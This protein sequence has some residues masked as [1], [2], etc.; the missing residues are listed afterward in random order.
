M[1]ERLHFMVTGKDPI[2]CEACEQR[3]THALRR[4]PGVIDVLASS[5]TQRV[6]VTVD[7]HRVDAEQ[8][9]SKLLQVGF[10]VGQE[11]R[12]G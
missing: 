10:E 12:R 1:T 8:V 5:E 7:P 6:E 11:G 4:L 9:Q 2:H 3:I